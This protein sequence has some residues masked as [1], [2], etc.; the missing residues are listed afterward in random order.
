MHAASVNPEP[1]SNSRNHSILTP[2][3]GRLKSIPSLI[4]HYFFLRVFL[5]S[6]LSRYFSHLLCFVL[7]LVVQFSRII[8]SPFCGDLHIITQRKRLVNTFFQNFLKFFL[9][10]IS[11]GA[12]PIY[13]INVGLS[14]PIFGAFYKQKRFALVAANLF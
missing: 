8:L 6:E 3:E 11:C 14:K 5:F 10:S 7:S 9:Q 1:G 13:I 4:A 12:N 2:G